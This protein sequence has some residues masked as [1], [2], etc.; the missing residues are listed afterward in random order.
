MILCM[1]VL[2]T[3]VLVV[4]AGK[5]RILPEIRKA[6]FFMAGIAILALL[7]QIAET[8]A[9]KSGMEINLA[10]PAYGEGDY[11]EEFTVDAGDVLD[12]YLYHVVVPEQTLSK[13]KEKELLEAAQQDIDLEFAKNN[14]EVT[15]KA[16]IREAYQEGKVDAVWE[17]EPYDVVDDN[18]VVIAETIP[19][20]GILVKAEVT[21][22]CESSEC[23]S[24]RYFRVMPEVLNEGQKLVKEIDRYLQRQVTDTGESLKLP[25]QLDGKKLVWNEKREYLPEKI[26]LFGMIMVLIYPFVE[27]SREKE[28]EKKRKALLDL[29]YAD[30]VSNL[31]LLLGAGMTVS[32][33]WNKLTTNYIG[34]RHNKAVCEKEVYEE[35]KRT[36]YEI[37]NGMGE[38]RAYERFGERCGGYRYRKFGNLLSQNLRKGSRGLTKL[39]EQEAEEAFEERKSMARKLGEEAGTKLLFPMLLMLG[40]VMV[41]LAFP[42]M[43]SMQL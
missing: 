3:A 33:A 36:A 42:A 34:K 9:Q 40:A 27:Q 23:V 21:L 19:D 16:G 2:G 15:G 41:I 4:V 29:Q 43:Y 35:M 1:G 7:M 14:G 8:K 26:L 25:E 17:F 28:K 12:G 38:E 31:A 37:K 22:K 6:A 39:L 11:E 32:G 20:E 30:M 13:Q 10:R 24:E 5:G 18:G